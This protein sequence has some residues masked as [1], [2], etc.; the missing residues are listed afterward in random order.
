MSSCS[1]LY[2]AYSKQRHMAK[3]YCCW[4]DLWRYKVAHTHTRA[5]T[6]G[7]CVHVTGNSVSIRWQRDR[8][9]T[10]LL[11]LQGHKTSYD[12][13]R[14]SYV[15]VITREMETGRKTHWDTDEGTEGSE[16]NESVTWLPV[17][18]IAAI[19]NSLTSAPLWKNKQTKKKRSKGRKT[20]SVSVE[21]YEPVEIFNCIME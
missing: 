8:T 7:V 19:W 3:G 17:L 18:L 15:L 6:G 13:D 5:H 10:V 1:L 20:L 4:L 12:T 9:V 11:P 2:K 21:S 16:G 14:N